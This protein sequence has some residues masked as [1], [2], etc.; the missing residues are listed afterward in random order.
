[1]GDIDFGPEAVIDQNAIMLRWFDHQLK[2]VAN[3][4]ENEKPVKIFVMGKNVW[5]EEDDWPLPRAKVTRY[6][7]HSNGK[8]NSLRGAGMLSTE[9]PPS[10]PADFFR[11]VSCL[12]RCRFFYCDILDPSGSYCGCA[13]LQDCIL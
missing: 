9:P 7:L 3:G 13:P 8:A 11:E 12:R 1:M 2:G 4:I 5:R 6:Y 10:E